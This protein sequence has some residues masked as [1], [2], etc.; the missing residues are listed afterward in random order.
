MSED[1]RLLPLSGVQH[2]V[3][4][5]RQAALIHVEQVWQEDVNTTRGRIVHERVDQEHGHDRRHGVSVMHAVPLMSRRLGLIGRA[6][7]VE[8][9][10]PGQAPLP[11]EHKRGAVKDLQADRVQLCAQAMCLEEMHGVTVPEGAL[12][13]TASKRRVPVVFDAALRQATVEA[14][15]RLHALVD[16]REVPRVKATAKCRQCSLKSLCLPEVTALP[17]TAAR[18]LAQVMALAMSD[19]DVEAVP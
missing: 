5:A 2:V 18:H 14:A 12:Y 9:G 11:V 8:Y 3:F 13:Y 15:A 16:R 17:G 10:A 1:D 19:A 7:S 6:D 4:C